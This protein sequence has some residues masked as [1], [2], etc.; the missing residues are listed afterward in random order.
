VKGEQCLVLDCW[1]F[2]VFDLVHKI[3]GHVGFL[4]VRSGLLIPMGRDEAVVYFL[5]V[6]FI[7]DVA[8]GARHPTLGYR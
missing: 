4:A 7:L 1:E 6:K 2:Q 3:D 8:I 5:T